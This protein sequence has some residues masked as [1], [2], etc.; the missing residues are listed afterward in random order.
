MGIK[1]QNQLSPKDRMIQVLAT[2]FCLILLI[3]IFLKV[4]IF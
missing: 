2:W 4:V 1:K 3:A